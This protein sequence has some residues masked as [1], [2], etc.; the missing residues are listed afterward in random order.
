MMSSRPGRI[1]RQQFGPTASVGVI[2]V[3][4]LLAGLGGAAIPILGWRVPV[5][6]LMLLSM[7]YILLDFRAGVAVTI[8]LMPLSPLAMFPH[9]MFGLRGANPLNLVMALTF[10][11]YCAHAAL[12]KWR[13][14]LLPSRLLLWYLLPISIAALVGMQHVGLIPRYFEDHRLI[15]FNDSLG[16]LRDM[17][18]KPLF[19]IV[20]A[21]LV[22]LAVRHSER[23]GRFLYLMIL[24]GW[25]FCALVALTLVSGGVS[26]RQ[27]ASPGARN[28]LG[29]L[30]MHANEIGLLINML[31]ALTLFSLRDRGPGLARNLLFISAVVF[32][33]CVMMTFS[34]GGV[35]GLL[36]INL[37]YFWKHLSLKTI[38]IGLVVI[39]C[40]GPFVASAV[41]ERMLTGVEGMDRGA[42]TA[43][44]FDQ[45]WLPLLPTVLAQPLLP[46]GLFAILWSEPA[47]MG[48]MMPVA[49]THSAWLAGVLDLGL[50]GFGFVLAFLLLVRREFLRLARQSGASVALAGTFAGGAMI[51]PLWFVQG[52]T[53]D[54]FTPVFS[55]TFFWIA[56]GMLMG[57]GGLYK[58]ARQRLPRMLAPAPPPVPGGPPSPSALSPRSPWTASRTAAPLHQHGGAAVATGSA[59]DTGV[60]R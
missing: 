42:V 5:A 27:L 29:K 45:I 14:P 17:L 48:R 4:V 38:M 54:R 3:L 60:P 43:G 39:A 8:V 16:Y 51:V 2:V 49:Q 57:C 9:E 11:S 30:G 50:I 15:Q 44:R 1:A 59:A 21:V 55:Q 26:L 46:H 34:R 22:A 53:D 6:A 36:L 12:H 13:D 24:S 37:V 40:I 47:K 58:P 10:L 19:L 56:L 33:V 7:V 41:A 28:A 52:L 20:L 25:I 32:A 18:F 23:P 31:Y 35:T